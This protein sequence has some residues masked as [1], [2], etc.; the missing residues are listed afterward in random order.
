MD[1]L[2]KA[3][4]RPSANALCGTVGRYEFGICGFEFLKFL[5]QEVVLAIGDLGRVV[6]VIE[7]V[8]TSDLVP[9]FLDLTRDCFS[10]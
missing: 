2:R 9:E 7:F 10:H 8:V 6:D 3:F 5:E 1:H 4:R